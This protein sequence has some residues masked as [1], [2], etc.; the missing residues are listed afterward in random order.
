MRPVIISCSNGQCGERLGVIALSL[1]SGN[2]RPV[3]RIEPGWRFSDTSHLHLGT[4]ERTD[5]TFAAERQL[6]QQI[7]NRQR[8][9]QGLGVARE[10]NLPVCVRCPKCRR[11]R[12]V[13][14]DAALVLAR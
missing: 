5:Y 1:L 7:T 3:W 4:L 2:P 14:P 8:P 10:V 13:A 12:W 6:Y 11:V 9:T